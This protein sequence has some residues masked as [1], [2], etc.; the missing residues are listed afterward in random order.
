MPPIRIL[1]LFTIMNRGGAETMVMN[2]YRNMD[3]SKVQFD[4]VVHRQERGAYDDEIELLGG[5]IYRMPA[6]RPWTATQYRKI[7][8]AFYAQHPEYRIIHSHMSELGYYDFIEAERSGIPVRICHAHNRPHGIDL[9][10]PVRW[11]YKTMM[12]PHIPHMFMCGEESGEWLF[13]K[14]NRNSFIQLNNAIEASQYRYNE[15]TREWIRKQL[16]LSDQLVVGHVGR[17]NPQKNHPFIIDVFEAVHRQWPDSVLL[18]VGD[19]S[20][21]GGKQIHHKVK[22]LGLE[23]NVKFLGIRSDVSDL[24]Q[25]MDVFL[26]PSLFEGLS[27]ASIE[28]QASGL[29]LLISDKVPIECKKTSSVQVISLTSPPE[30]WAQK[31]IEAAHT[32]RVDTYDEI[33]TAG[34][35]IAENAKWLQNYYLE[36]WKATD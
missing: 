2:Y 22:S 32:D 20:C 18:L 26:F 21:D 25:A 10:S 30:I 15:E 28:A 24:L 33:A 31:V 12:M 23:N 8:R 13:G 36:H 11:Y 7:I 27:V 5:K 14:K 1:N 29:P 34:F 19:D 4:F 17:F 16:G 3:R 6:I 9:K 35:D